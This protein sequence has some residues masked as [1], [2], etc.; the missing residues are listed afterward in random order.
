MGFFSKS[1]PE[2][3]R[4]AQVK[5]VAKALDARHDAA[6][7]DEGPSGRREYKRAEATLDAAMRNATEAEIKAAYRAMRR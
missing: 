1:Q 7:C 3:V 2:P 6:V 5:R 4:S